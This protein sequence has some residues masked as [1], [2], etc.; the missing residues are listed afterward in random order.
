[1]QDSLKEYKSGISQYSFFLYLH[2]NDIFCKFLN[3]CKINMQARKVLIFGQHPM[4]LNAWWQEFYE[5]DSSRRR[6]EYVKH[7][8]TGVVLWRTL[9]LEQ[10]PISS[11]CRPLHCRGGACVVSPAASRR[12]K[13]SC[14]STVHPLSLKHFTAHCSSILHGPTSAIAIYILKIAAMQYLG[15]FFK[16]KIVKKCRAPR[17][18]V[19]F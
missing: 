17:K 11:P 6:P 13:L 10:A 19:L 2:W 9:D 4:A 14:P 15:H 8:Q 16:F 18:C 7:R 1:M 3:Y 5:L 12:L